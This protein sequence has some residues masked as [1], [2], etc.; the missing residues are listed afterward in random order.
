M[1]LRHSSK[2]LV[3]AL[4]ILITCMVALSVSSLLNSKNDNVR[5]TIFGQP[6]REMLSKAFSI[7]KNVGNDQA[8]PIVFLEIDD[9]SWKDY[10][11]S[12]K[13][14]DV[15]SD[16]IPRELAS[17]LLDF[18]LLAPP[19]RGA[20]AVL[21]NV[22]LATQTGDPSGDERMKNTL[23]RW[24]ATANAPP[25]I[26]SR[27]LYHV[28]YEG[29]GDVRGRSQSKF[30]PITPYDEIVNNSNG[31]IQWAIGEAAPDSDGVVRLF[32]PWRCVSTAQGKIK[33]PSAALAIYRAADPRSHDVKVGPAC[34]DDTQGAD[35]EVINYNYSFQI[36]QPKPSSGPDLL[37]V[38]QPVSYGTVATSWPGRRACGI[39]DNP[40]IVLAIPAN[41]VAPHTPDALSPQEAESAAQLCHRIAIIGSTARLGGLPLA[42][43]LKDMPTS[44]IFGN[45]VRGL[46]KTNGGLKPPKIEHQ[47]LFDITAS[48]LFWAIYYSANA[49]SRWY[50]RTNALREEFSSRD[51]LSRALSTSAEIIVNPVFFHWLMNTLIALGSI[52]VSVLAIERGVWG[53]FSA[54][55]FAASVAGAIQQTRAVR[56]S[57]EHARQSFEQRWAELRCEAPN[58]H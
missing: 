49:F 45:T 8:N 44:M 6:D 53:Y 26:I 57:I 34:H 10:R 39:E 3:S 13:P 21:L 28:E 58:S 36:E 30:L 41:A 14:F 11:G 46:E 37:P 43:P 22:D 25:L 38:R 55:A 47:I 12:E 40:P 29:A 16:V 35:F 1:K 7:S 2:T 19:G 4:Q 32:Q 15:P 56:D 20:A 5:R 50:A 18:V 31:R 33:L 23:A 48:V 9:A 52:G 42:T 17:K 51:L 54:P 24:S 27:K